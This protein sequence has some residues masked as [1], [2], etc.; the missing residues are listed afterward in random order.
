MLFWVLQGDIRCLCNK[1][2]IYISPE[3]RDS[4]PLVVTPDSSSQCLETINPISVS[5]DF[6]I[7]DISYWW[8]H[9]HMTFC[10]WLLS[11]SINIFKMHPFSSIQ[12]ALAL[13]FFNEQ[14]SIAWIYILFINSSV[15]GYLGCFYLWLWWIMLL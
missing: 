12:Q 10:V 9:T 2:D 1:K 15:D 14:Y 3:G 5:I 8:N 4:Y 6:P 11:L 13:H 7:L